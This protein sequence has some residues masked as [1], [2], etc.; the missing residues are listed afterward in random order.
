MLARAGRA[1]QTYGP[2]LVV[3]LVAGL[4]AS[5]SANDF[6]Q[7]WWAGHLIAIGRSPYDPAAW[8]AALAYGPAAGAVA[9]NCLAPDAAACLWIYPPWTAWMFAPSGALGPEAGIAVQRVALLSA[10]ALGGV[11][12][13]RAARATDANVAP[14]LVAL[15]A[16]APFVRDVVTGHFEG[17]LLIGL[18]LLATGLRETRT[19]RIVA[20]A[21]LLA[22]KP[23]LFLALP[24][25]VLVWLVS[26]RAYR[27]L[28]V[29]MLSLAALAIAGFASDPSAWPALVGRFTAKQELADGTTWGFA[30]AIAGPGAPAV[31]AIL[32][33]V[34]LV[35]AVLAWRWARSPDRAAVL[36]GAGSALS[37]AVAPYLQSYDLVLLFPAVALALATLRRPAA[38]VA[39]AVVIAATWL[40]Y[41]LELSGDPRAFAGAMPAVTLVAL[42]LGVRPRLA[43]TLRPA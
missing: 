1:A 3:V 23:H 11:L 28:A 21:L 35:A 6:F 9:H 20:S 15:A 31:G 37:L 26:R 13:V 36:V 40:A 27:G 33:V 12:W 38:V 16:S 14:L 29:T 7:F 18:F 42:A 32:V 19:W 2:F 39:A 41:V 5:P 43:T 4:L 25:L 30:A 17:V 10:L 22:L 24:P 34:A 8:S